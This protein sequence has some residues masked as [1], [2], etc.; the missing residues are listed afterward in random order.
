MLA[1][2]GSLGVGATNAI[3]SDDEASTG[4]TFTAGAVDLT[5]D[6]ESY[7]NGELNEGTT[8]LEARNLDDGAG[9]AGGEYLFF[10]FG[11]VKPGDWGE[12]T[13]SLH[14]DDNDSWLCIDVT[15]T[16]DDDNGFTEPEESD[17]D[18]T[19]GVGEGEL[20]DAIDF[21]WWADDGDNVYEDDEDLLPAGPLGNLEVGET[22]VVALADSS[23]NIWDEEG[24]LPGDSVRFI[25][26]AW[27]LGDMNSDPVAQDGEGKTGSNGPLDRGTG[28]TCDGSG[29][30]NI[31]QTDS[32]TADIVFYAEQARH[33]GE[34]LCGGEPDRPTTITIEKTIVNDDQ[35]T[36]ETADFTFFLNGDEVDE[37]VAAVVATG[38]YQVSE[39]GPDGYL[40]TFGG[41]CDA[42]GEITVT[43]GEQ[44]VC[45]IE[46]DD[47]AEPLLTVDKS[48]S[49]SQSGLSVDPANFDFTLTDD[50]TFD[51]Y[52]FNDEI[53]GALPAGTYTITET[54]TGVQNLSFTAIFSG[55]CS[56]I[57]GSD[58]GTITV[59]EGQSYTCDVINQISAGNGFSG[60]PVGDT[61]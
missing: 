60:S 30:N 21:M 25:G 22:A 19:D 34:F 11:D 36:A 55:D 26:K 61:D 10:N 13:I 15:L 46:N 8:W 20:A 39:E 54:Y 17:G 57:G 50:S 37:G 16:S 48:V 58:T 31:T 14:V 56:E 2:V 44:A 1:I 5:V 41:D 7:Y 23:G 29:V 43:K 52:V 35:G 42:N 6:N 53:Q 49:Y 45:T 59:E 38:T 40:A 33:N 18:T 28:F 12:D 47:T 9:P 3:F 24:P 27:C 32:M 51:E 4:N